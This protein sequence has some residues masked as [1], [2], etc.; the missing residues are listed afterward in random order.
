MAPTS[1]AP[2]PVHP[3]RVHNSGGEKPTDGAWR[4]RAPAQLDRLSS[5]G[6]EGRCHG[7]SVSRM[8]RPAALPA[9]SPPLR[10]AR[11]HFMR[12]LFLLK[13]DSSIKSYRKQRRGVSSRD[14][15]DPLRA[16]TTIKMGRS[17]Q[18]HRMSKINC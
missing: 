11:S 18:C 10:S 3:E 12:W 7:G 16:Q 13:A 1:A 9:P 4:R 6:G 14:N 2:F 17:W 8:A 15:R 5:T